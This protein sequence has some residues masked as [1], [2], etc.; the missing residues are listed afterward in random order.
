MVYRILFT[1]LLFRS[2]TVGPA[3]KLI[4]TL[5]I[6]SSVIILY[7]GVL[8]RKYVNEQKAITAAAD[9]P[10]SVLWCQPCK[11]FFSVIRTLLIHIVREVWYRIIKLS[12]SP[13][14]SCQVLLA[15][16][17]LAGVRYTGPTLLP[18]PGSSLHA[19][20]N[21]AGYVFVF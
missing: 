17:K 4:R 10:K 7:L 14:L 20:V 1:Y 8:A 18:T 11:K 13:K 21:W 12:F 19:S 2:T 5:E 15:D 3:L 6:C 16:T 9:K